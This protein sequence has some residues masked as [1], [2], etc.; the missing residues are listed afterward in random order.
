MGNLN[1][2]KGLL[3]FFTRKRHRHQKLE[4]FKKNKKPEKKHNM[5]E[6]RTVSF[7]TSLK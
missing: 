7:K 6:N 2:K 5:L 3:K 4:Q 1:V